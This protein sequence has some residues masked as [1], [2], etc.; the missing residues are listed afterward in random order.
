M[1]RGHIRRRGLHSW[2]LK[3]DAGR[4][5]AGNRK[6]QYVAFRGSKREAQ[7][8]LTQLLAAVGQGDYVEPSRAT[9]ADFVRARV[10]QWEAAGDISARTAQ[11]YR[12]L[13]ENQIVPH[14]GNKVLQRLARLD[15][16]GWHTALRI[17]GL[18]ARTVGHAHRV[19]SKAL[20]DA[21]RDGA[22]TKNVC[23]LQRVPRVADTEMVIVRDVPGFIRKIEGERLYVPAI[24]ALTTGMRLGE[25]LALKDRR[26]D[27]GAKTIEVSEALEETKARGI[28]SKAPK[29]K[30]GHRT[31]TL[32]DITVEALREHRRRLLETR[33]MLGLGKLS[34]DDL[35]FANLEGRPL[36]PS[37]VSSDWGELAGRIGV[38]ELT[39]HGLR[40]THAS[41]LVASGVDIVTISKRLGHARPA[42]TLAI[43][44]HMFTSDDSK[45]AAAIN[46]ALT[47]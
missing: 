2:E 43:Y 45:A 35:V 26:I 17:S 23:K 12:Q 8:K 1:S 24:V 41:Q 39:F 28:I 6:I 5:P 46:A 44:A 30:A 19:L 10:D 4:D 33:L 37:A 38:P 7:A 34:P 25:I 21:E 42:V 47:R 40:H 29:S 31:L 20:G 3:F 15:I 16:E 18:A 36:R 11:R 32:P 22:V 9:V 14:L 13:V 27:L